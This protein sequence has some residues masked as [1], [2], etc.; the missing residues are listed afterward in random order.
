MEEEI[1]KKEK[2]TKIQNPD[3]EDTIENN[4][5]GTTAKK[6]EEDKDADFNF[7]GEEDLY[8]RDE[9]ITHEEMKDIEKETKQNRIKLIKYFL[10]E[11]ET[12]GQAIQRLKAA[13][14]EKK[15]KPLKPQRKKQKNE[16]NSETIKEDDATKVDSLR[17][18]ALFKELLDIV[19][20]LTELSFFNVYS[21]CV[22]N[23]Q[24]SYG[25]AS[26]IKW[27]YRT[28]PV[29]E[30]FDLNNDFKEYG[31]FTSEE[32]KSWMNGVN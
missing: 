27:K 28:V 25:M 24:K 14:G 32:I 26:L 31:E 7:Y 21:D 5:D 22:V 3:T 2:E 8:Y 23:I 12:V 30:K 19:S 10:N 4:L 18:Q 13:G 29:G 15:F 9:K 11:N 6:D 16:E 20:K 1:K 17:N